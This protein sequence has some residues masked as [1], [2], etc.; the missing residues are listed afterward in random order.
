ME[1]NEWILKLENKNQVVY[2]EYVASLFPLYQL[3]IKFA[4]SR[5]AAFFCIGKERFGFLCNMYYG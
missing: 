4:D 1:L 2:T 3:G 5:D